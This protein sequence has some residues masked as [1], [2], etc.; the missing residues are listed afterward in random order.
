M[1]IASKYLKK[2]QTEK[3][4][5]DI[6]TDLFNESFYGFIRQFNDDFLLLEHYNDDGLFNGIIVFKREDITRIKWANNDINSAHKI[7]NK[8]DQEKNIESIKLDSLEVIL[9][10]ISKAFKHVNINIQNIDNGMCIIGEI[11]EMDAESIVI[12][13][14]GSRSSLDRGRIMFAIEDIT[15]IDAG[16]LY[17][18]GLLKVHKKKN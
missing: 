8:H 14:F 9:K 11:E 12:K 4:F 1:N 2:L 5:V 7:I 3:S 10:S 17:E 13:E 18:N 15:R 16:G 6:F